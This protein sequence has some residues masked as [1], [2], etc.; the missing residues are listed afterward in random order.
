MKKVP[1]DAVVSDLVGYS[2]KALKPVPMYDGLLNQINTLPAKQYSPPVSGWIEQG[3]QVYLS[4]ENPASYPLSIYM[5]M[6]GGFW[7]GYMYDLS[8][9]KPNANPEPA[10]PFKISFTPLIV[11]AIAAILILR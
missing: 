9:S 6:K 1:K 4:F 10:N 5:P 8:P 11:G 3:G 7:D 2:L